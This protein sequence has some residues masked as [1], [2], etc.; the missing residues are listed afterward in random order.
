M[1]K[2][3]L[4]AA[5]FIAV[6]AAAGAD[7]SAFWEPVYEGFL[8]YAADYVY[9]FD[10]RVEIAG[11]DAWTVAGAPQVG[12]PWITLTSPGGGVFYQHPTFPNVNP[13]NPALFG[14]YPDL[15]YDSFYTT[16]LGWPNTPDQGVGAQ[17]ADAF[18]TPTALF[19]DWF[20]VPDE[21]DYPGTF[22]IARF[23]VQG[24]EGLNPATNYATIDMQVG[25]REVV[26]PIAY[27]A[28]VPIP[29][30]ASLALLALGGLALLRRR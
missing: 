29:E 27:T 20:W 1:C 24:P 19:A 2:N 11:A 15:A 9:S 30:P 14:D 7:I 21:F 23:T 17:F 18:S 16:H 5:S 26:P 12:D 13:P 4:V 28:R 6:A 8:P 25:S 10:L 3:L 22:T